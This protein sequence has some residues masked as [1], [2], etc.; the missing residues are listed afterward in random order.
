MK[1]FSRRAFGLLAATTLAA[2]ILATNVTAQDAKNVLSIGSDVTEII[3][4]L[5]AQDRLVA[6]D[7]TSRYPAA[8]NALPDVGYMRALSPE[9]VLS[10]DPGLILASEG[11][12]PLET[13]DVLKSANVEYVSLGRGYAPEDV[14]AK[15]RKI[16]DALDMSEAAEA[17][18]SDTEATLSAQKAKADTIEGTRKRIMFVLSIRDGKITVSGR[19]TNAAAMIKLA[20]GMNALDSFSGYKTLSDEA[21]S[22][23]APDVILMMNAGG[24]H[25]ATAEQV[26]ALPSLAITPAAENQ[27]LVKIDGIFI[28]GSGPRTAGAAE[29]LHSAIYGGS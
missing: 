25:G 26:F 3:Y 10:V 16:G 1:R 20:G 2:P 15:I 17:L 21:A 27:T 24:S 13:I 28:N 18:A 8:A 19:D 9:G 11:A 5:G 14:A 7:T 4:A 29:A 6:R 12:G 23:A 22:S